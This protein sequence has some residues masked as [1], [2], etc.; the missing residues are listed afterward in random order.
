MKT[1]IKTSDSTSSLAIG[2]N[3]TTN[4]PARL[5]PK[6]QE[7]VEAAANSS[8]PSDV[9]PLTTEHPGSAANDVAREATPENEMSLSNQ[10]CTSNITLL[11][12]D[13]YFSSIMANADTMGVCN[14]LPTE[15][16]A[17]IEETGSGTSNAQTPESN[18]LLNLLSQNLSDTEP[19]ESIV[20]CVAVRQNESHVTAVMSD[21]KEE[22]HLVGVKDKLL[23]TEELLK[24]STT[25]NGVNVPSEFRTT[26]SFESNLRKCNQNINGR[27]GIEEP[28]A[29]LDFEHSKI[30][31]SDKSISDSIFPEYLKLLLDGMDV[32]GDSGCPLDGKPEWFDLDKFR[33]G[34][35]V[36]KKYLFG[37]LLAETLSLFMLLNF[38]STIQTLIFTRKSDTPYKSFKRYL[39]TVTRVRSW[40]F[41]DIWQPG[42]EGHKN[43]R[44]VRAMHEKARRELN[45]TKL[46]EV[47]KKGTL[48]R[49]CTFG[50][51][52]S[53]IW[54]PLHGMI[55]ED[56]QGSC[57][58]PRP[59]QRT[60][61]N[62]QQNPVFLNQM[63][64]AITQFGFVG[65][66]ILF[67]R[68]FGAHNVSDED[69][70]AFVY[71]WRCIGYILGTDDI[72]NLCNGDL[73]TVRQRSR[74][75]INFWVKPNL[76]EVSRD[77]EHMTRCIVEGIHYYVPGITYEI[78]LLYLCSMLDIYAPRI[79]AA[80]TFTQVI[81]YHVMNFVFLVL[82]RLS[83]ACS[84]LNWLLNEAIRI[85][86][87][88]SP[89]VLTK[90]Q[91]KQYP[92][93]E[94]ATC[95]RL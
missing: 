36:A 18:V 5:G 45:N 43:I 76:R 24:S 22:Y 8:V 46:D 85:A 54:S 33:R 48:S 66:F 4:L 86:Q 68:K 21:V 84:L 15:N 92:H 37:L 59:N 31:E 7:S 25:C 81:M 93:E 17:D 3:N 89:K 65:L 34:Q 75:I 23:I 73:E 35:Q 74:D 20:S 6:T 38:A 32:D 12:C 13:E 52:G 42:T 79:R 95:T 49:S 14:I 56:F 19:G 41:E 71:L 63:E 83:F 2:R 67:P 64:M 62:Y 39:S 61:L 16:R 82:M 44:A 94:E 80:L 78:A 30:E 28:T 51:K 29:H 1:E 47:R 69:M 88:A 70:S 72:Y 26:G 60:F 27:T 40:Y 9:S 53:V 50:C 90:L 91:M 77:W 10:N 58:Y 55:R 57:P 87:S 11:K